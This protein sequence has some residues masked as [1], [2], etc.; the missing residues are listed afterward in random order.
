MKIVTENFLLAISIFF[1][2]TLLSLINSK[3]SKIFLKKILI[4]LNRVLKN[5]ECNILIN[6]G[7]LISQ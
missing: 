4:N 1:N 3:V 2:G 7:P 5:C 6:Q